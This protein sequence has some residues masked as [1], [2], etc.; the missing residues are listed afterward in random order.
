M[1]KSDF[2]LMYC[3][4]AVCSVNLSS[5]YHTHI[6]AHIMMEFAVKIVVLLCGVSTTTTGT[7]LP[8]GKFVIRTKISNRISMQHKTGAPSAVKGLKDDK[9]MLPSDLQNF[10]T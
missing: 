1:D 6:V 7:L 10:K 9:I 5:L 8:P 2:C 3:Y 4:T